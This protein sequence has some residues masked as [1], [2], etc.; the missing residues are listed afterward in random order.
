MLQEPFFYDYCGSVTESPGNC[1][2]LR[3]HKSIIEAVKKFRKSSRS[4]MVV[5]KFLTA[6]PEVHPVL[7]T[8]WLIVQLCTPNKAN[9]KIGKNKQL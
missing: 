5:L 2:I 9:L 8:S 7:A 1:E 3:L 6:S 4:D